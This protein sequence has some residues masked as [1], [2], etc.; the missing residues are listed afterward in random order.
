MQHGKNGRSCGSDKTAAKSCLEC[1]RKSL[2]VDGDP[3][4]GCIASSTN[5]HLRLCQIENDAVKCVE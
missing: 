4:A 2:A 3:K 5:E 1:L